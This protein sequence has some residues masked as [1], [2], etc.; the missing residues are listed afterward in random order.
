MEKRV[1]GRDEEIGTEKEVD[2]L[3]EQGKRAG[4]SKTQ[5][6]GSRVVNS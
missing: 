5:S 4:N 6:Q 1:W 2:C 3:K